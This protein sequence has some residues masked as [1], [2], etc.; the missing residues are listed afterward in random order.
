MK[1][2]AYCIFYLMNVY[3]KFLRLFYFYRPHPSVFLKPAVNKSYPPLSGAKPWT[4][5]QAKAYG[6]MIVT[7]LWVGGEKLK[8][9]LYARCFGCV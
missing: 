7:K 5:E 1:E 9:E 8:N 6:E 2:A 4:K 3:L